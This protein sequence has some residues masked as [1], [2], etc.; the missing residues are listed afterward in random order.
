MVNFFTA[1]F[2]QPILNLVVAIYNILP[3]HDIGWTI[4]I[5]TVIIKAVLYPLSKKAIEGQKSLQNLQPK[6]EEIKKK[7][8]GDKEASSRAMMELYRQEKVSPLSSCLPLLI[9]LPFFWAIFKV[10]RDEL[11]GKSL[12]MIYPFISN[13]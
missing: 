12:I 2:Y 7:H 10:F 11:M 6:L 3:G 5:L 9:Q 4:V 8:A 13:P 1:V